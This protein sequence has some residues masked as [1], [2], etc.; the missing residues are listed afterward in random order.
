MRAERYPR[1]EEDQLDLLIGVRRECG[2]WRLVG[3]LAACAVSFDDDVCEGTR[4]GARKGPLLIRFPQP[5][6]HD[7]DEAR[8]ASS[9]IR[10]M[11]SGRWPS[12]LASV[13]ACDSRT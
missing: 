12:L 9:I 7:D 1:E 11:S 2:E 13:V 5:G 4:E 6:L 10:L 8:R 3:W